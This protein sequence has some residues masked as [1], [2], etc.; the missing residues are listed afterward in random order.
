MQDYICDVLIIGAGISGLSTALYLRDF[1]LNVIILEKKGH[2]GENIQCGE[3][4]GEYLI[5]FL[6]KKLRNLVDKFTL[7]RLK[8]MFLYDIDEKEM[9]IIRKVV[10]NKRIYL[11][12]VIDRASFEKKLYNILYKS[13][14][15]VFLFKRKIKKIVLNNND[16]IS[17]VVTTKER[18][19][20]K[21]VVVADGANSFVL[22]YLKKYDKTKKA[23]AISY[24]VILSDSSELDKDYMHEFL[25]LSTGYGF[26]IPK[27]DK[28]CNIGIGGLLSYENKQVLRKKFDVLF[29]ISE[30]KQM[31][32]SYEILQQKS[33][34][35][36]I[37]RP[38]TT[39]S[40][41][42][43]LVVGDAG[44]NVLLPHVEGII[45]SL[46]SGVVA[47]NILRKYFEYSDFTILYQFER[48]LSN[49]PS[50]FQRVYCLLYNI[51]HTRFPFCMS[52]G[53]L[54]SYSKE[55]EKNMISF[56]PLGKSRLF[57][58]FAETST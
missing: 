22:N 8:G 12:R 58:I 17:C 15:I 54:L 53:S 25:G 56:L 42:N 43:V 41:G 5:P 7:R 49:Y 50:I 27:T 37:G 35:A 26:I 34:Y 6:P 29:S 9:K 38:T 31:I 14:D 36:V 57:D 20:P 2:V 51:L 40:F 11:G 30:V 32:G 24:E 28:V 1:G 44:G 16:K 23:Y 55:I 13:S 21:I 52:Y 39:I 18:I 33:G 47:A 19:F 48:Y 46:I 10:Q 45:P 4:V 3:A